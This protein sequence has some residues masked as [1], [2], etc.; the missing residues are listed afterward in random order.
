MSKAQH[1]FEQ[2][3][4]GDAGRHHARLRHV[5]GLIEQ[6]AGRPKASTDAA[7]DES[8]RISAAYEIAP[9]VAQRRYDT[10]VAEVSGWAASG[11]DALAGIKDPR[12]QPRIAAERLAE[13]LGRSLAEMTRLL[14]A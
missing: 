2:P 7:L 13:E 14:R 5:L 10:M 8:A 1:V 3:G 11:V 6:I 4:T 12:R 9:P